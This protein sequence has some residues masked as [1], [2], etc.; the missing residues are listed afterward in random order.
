MPPSQKQPLA[1]V[2]QKPKYVLLKLCNIHRKI[3]V[4]ESHFNKHY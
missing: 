1:G 3:P 2:L 4:L